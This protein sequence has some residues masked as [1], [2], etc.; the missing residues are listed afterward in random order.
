MHVC[1]HEGVMH[2]HIQSAQAA[3]T[4]VFPWSKR[5]GGHSSWEFDPGTQ[6]RLQARMPPA[7]PFLG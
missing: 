6:A 4:C 5:W 3:R 1:V 7:L 2:V